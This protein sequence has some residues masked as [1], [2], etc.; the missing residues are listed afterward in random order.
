ML[1]CGDHCSPFLRCLHYYHCLLGG[2]VGCHR[3]CIWS[4]YSCVILAELQVEAEGYARPYAYGWHRKWMFQHAVDKCWFFLSLSV[5]QQRI[6][7]HSSPPPP[8]PPKGPD[9]IQLQPNPSYCSVE[10]AQQWQ[11]NSCMLEWKY[12]CI[13]E[14]YQSER[15]T[16]YYIFVELYCDHAGHAWV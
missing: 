15:D 2:T 5:S 4:C 13:R 8:L 10:R 12:I 11:C 3:D 7:S 1:V 14:R 16:S 6:P 9:S